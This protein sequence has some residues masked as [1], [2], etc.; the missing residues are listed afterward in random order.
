MNNRNTVA[1]EIMQ[2][3]AIDRLERV[4]KPFREGLQTNHLLDVVQLFAPLFV[5]LFTFSGTLQCAQVLDAIFVQESQSNDRDDEDEQ[6]VVWVRQYVQ[7]CSS[8][9][10]LN[11]IAD[12]TSNCSFA[13]QVFENLLGIVLVA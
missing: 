13:S 12:I 6:L 8:E 7:E 10:M 4:L 2:F 11:N 1:S 5:D 3:E 9:G